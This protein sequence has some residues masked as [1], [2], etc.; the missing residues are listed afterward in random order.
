LWSLYRVALWIEDP[1]GSDGNDL[2]LKLMQTSSNKSLVSLM[3]SSSHLAP[4][5]E[6]NEDLIGRFTMGFTDNQRYYLSLV[7]FTDET[8]NSRWCTRMSECR[9]D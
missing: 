7:L 1:G 8:C 3:M 5:F 4:Q 9:R 2:L 6:F